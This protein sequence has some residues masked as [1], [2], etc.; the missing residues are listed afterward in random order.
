M[1]FV[2]FFMD[3]LQLLAISLN[4]ANYVRDYFLI[5]YLWA[6]I[7]AYQ[8]LQVGFHVHG[9]N[10][11]RV[12][13]NWRDLIFVNWRC[14]FADFWFAVILSDFGLVVRMIMIYWLYFAGSRWSILSFRLTKRHGSLRFLPRFRFQVAIWGLSDHWLVICSK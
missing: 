10:I 6:T 14:I 5:F 3:L 11:W 7:F 1:Y 13:L 2:L 9:V 12:F 4:I 8:L